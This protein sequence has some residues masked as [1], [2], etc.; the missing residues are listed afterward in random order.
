[1]IW[2]GI[3]LI[4]LMAALGAPLFAVL[5]AASMLGFYSADIDL[6]I[7]AIELYRIVD[8]PL[9]V[10]LPLFT[11]SGYLLSEA[12][13]STRLV[14]LMQSLFGFLPSGLAI[15][16]F[17]ACAIFTALTGASGVTIVAL[18]AL[19]L[20]A[21]RQ[22]GFAEKFSM[23]LVTTSGSL[24]LLLVPSVPLILYGVIAQQLD[25]G[26][27]FAIVDLFVAGIAPM[28]LMLVM[29]SGWTLWR[30]RGG[31]IPRVPFKWRNVGAALWDARWEVPLPFVVLGGVFSGLFAIS[32]AAAVTALYVVLAE[33]FGYRE[34]NL[35]QLAK[36]AKESMVMVG[37]I[38]L[39]L[40]VALGFTNFLVDAEVPQQLMALMQEHIQSPLSFLLL[41]NILLLILGAML[42]IFAALVIMVP[43]L[44]PVAVG[45]GIHPVHL[46]IIFLA[47]MQVGYFTPPVGMNLFIASYRFKKPLT[48]LYAAT[49]PFMLILL[50]AVLI[51]TYVPL[52]ST[53]HLPS[54]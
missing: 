13:T 28:L 53:W 27:P 40:G 51:I 15:V 34:I 2:A 22:A 1:M 41:L 38:L 43:L 49:L 47:N 9:L 21:L 39:I 14:N 54:S 30:H 37:G 29:L 48:E 3:A 7:V 24:G 46:G 45:Y 26:E 31:E 20:P 4:L 44:L 18:G 42:D 23:G 5:L 8:T 10:A 32:E 36:V 50:L 12:N 6:A 19:L 33:V 52:L 16:A 25:L 11:F 35:R 17:V